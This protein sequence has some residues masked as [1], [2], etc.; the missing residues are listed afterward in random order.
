MK[1]VDKDSGMYISVHIPKCAGTSLRRALKQGLGDRFEADYGDRIVQ[2]DV[3]AIAWRRERKDKMLKRLQKGDIA[4]VHGHFYASKYANAPFDKVWL[5]FIRDPV[6]L[7]LSYYNFLNRP[8]L[9]GPLVKLA[10]EL[11]LEEWRRHSPLFEADVRMA[12]TPAASIAKKRT[13]QS[14][15]PDAVRT[16][17]AE[18][19][20]W[21]SS[22]ALRT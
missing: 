10:K 3:S 11:S 1:L 9:R 13:P 14:T 2:G 8:N 12:I 17:L 4:L 5:T 7:V 20:R 21:L 6:E 22:V 15:H 16:S 19:Q 18:L